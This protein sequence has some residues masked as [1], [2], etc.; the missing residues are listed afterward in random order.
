MCGSNLIDK[1]MAVC[2]RLLL[3]IIK[4]VSCDGLRGTLL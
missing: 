1:V 4:F 2:K 3:C